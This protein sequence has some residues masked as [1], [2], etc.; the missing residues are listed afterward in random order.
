MCNEQYIIF[1]FKRNILLEFLT[2][3]RW[4]NAIIILPLLYSPEMF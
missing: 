3:Y 4:Q 2:I 1:L